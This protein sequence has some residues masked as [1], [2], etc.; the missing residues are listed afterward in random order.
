MPLQRFSLVCVDDVLKAMI[1][2]QRL[3]VY[4]TLQRGRLAVVV[5][6]DRDVA[7]P[8]SGLSLLDVVRRSTADWPS[9][10]ALERPL[11]QSWD[12]WIKDF[13]LQIPS[14]YSA[15]AVLRCEALSSASDWIDPLLSSSFLQHSGFDRLIP[16]LQDFSGQP[17]LKP[18]AYLQKIP[19]QSFPPVAVAVQ[20]EPCA[21]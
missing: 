3:S 8:F 7:C 19:Q 12:G 1:Q 10:Y 4:E 20:T 11:D 5:L 2:L 17:S 6:V 9:V 14:R 21:G 15:C 13:T 16:S 18:A